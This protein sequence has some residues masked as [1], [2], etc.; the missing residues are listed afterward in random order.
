MYTQSQLQAALANRAKP[1]L[2]P[3]QLAKHEAALAAYI[4]HVAERGV[5]C[6]VTGK[7]VTPEQANAN[8][9]AWNTAQAEAV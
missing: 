6:E 2:T 9:A 4:A 1:D 7:Y 8:I 3:A 5:L